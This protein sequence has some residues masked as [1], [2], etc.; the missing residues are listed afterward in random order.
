MIIGIL[1]TADLAQAGY[2]HS[3]RFLVR[4]RWEQVRSHHPNETA[5]YVYARQ[6]V[7]GISAIHVDGDICFEWPTGRR[8][9]EVP[10]NLDGM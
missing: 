8:L 9:Q 2:K 3:S 7:C 5:R 4:H 6:R 1:S 10:E